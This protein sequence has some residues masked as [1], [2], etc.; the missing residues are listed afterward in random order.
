MQFGLLSG[1][2]TP[3]TVFSSD[4]HRSYRVVPPITE[5]VLQILKKE[6]WPL[7]DK[8]QTTAAGLALSYILSYPEISTVIPGIRTPEHVT[9]NTNHLIQIEEADKMHLQNLYESDWLK[10]M[11]M[12]ERQ[13]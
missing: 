6:V 1:K 2:I 8:Y 10:V 4:D 12:M 7:C 11:A 3:D 5:A 9:L 13:G